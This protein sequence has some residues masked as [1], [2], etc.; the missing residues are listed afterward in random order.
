M[1]ALPELELS[2]LE[3]EMETTSP[4]DEAPDE[5]LDESAAGAL[6]AMQNSC[7]ALSSPLS[8]Q[9][10]TTRTL[11][12]FPLSLRVLRLRVWKRLR[13]PDFAAAHAEA[14]QAKME[15]KHPVTVY[16]FHN[17]ICVG[18]RNATREKNHGI[19][20]SSKEVQNCI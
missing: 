9:V 11:R 13:S 2:E 16:S 20:A 8:S 4:L 3:L 14:T 19:S 7:K 6:A 1:S 17:H 5:L 15:K 12:F 10:C 18:S